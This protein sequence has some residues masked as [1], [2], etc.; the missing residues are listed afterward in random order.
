MI[1]QWKQSR[2][3]AAAEYNRDGRVH[4]CPLDLTH[5]TGL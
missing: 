4:G 3:G 5:I 2:S 1:G